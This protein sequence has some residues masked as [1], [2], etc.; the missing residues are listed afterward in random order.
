MPTADLTPGTIT[1]LGQLRPG[2]VG[3]WNGF[4]DGAPKF[5]VVQQTA[6]PGFGVCVDALYDGGGS[7]SEPFLS[8]PVR[9]LGRGRIEPARIVM[10]G[11][12]DRVAELEQQVRALRGIAVKLDSLDWIPGYEL[13]G[14]N[15]AILGDAM[16][17]ARAFLAATAPKEKPCTT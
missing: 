6:Y 8:R 7:I 10:G 16:D 9:Y 12:P 5:V 2:D 14:G 4:G 1:T 17:A 13:V 3:E 15:H 11:E